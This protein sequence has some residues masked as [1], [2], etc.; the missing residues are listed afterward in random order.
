MVERHDGTIT[1]GDSEE[2][3]G[4]MFVVTLPTQQRIMGPAAHRGQ[5]SGST[6]D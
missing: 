1:V 6:R 2:L 3:G 5:D 4:A